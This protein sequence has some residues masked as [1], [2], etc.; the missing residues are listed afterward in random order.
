MDHPVLRKI[1]CADVWLPE[2]KAA[3][4]PGH[5]VGRDPGGS[6]SGRTWGGKHELYVLCAEFLGKAEILKNAVFQPFI[7]KTHD[8]IIVS[9]L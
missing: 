8:I 1:P 5:P 6:N 9:P 3:G 7:P 4:I 2:G